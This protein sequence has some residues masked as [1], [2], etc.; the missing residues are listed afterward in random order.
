MSAAASVCVKPTISN[1]SFC[2]GTIYISELYYA[3]PLPKLSK[4]V[5]ELYTRVTYLAAE[6]L[7]INLG[8]SIRTDCGIAVLAEDLYTTL[9]NMVTTNKFCGRSKA[10]DV[11]NVSKIIF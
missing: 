11:N 5:N 7:C 10:S 3:T 1:V 8:P 2:S 4:C 6:N 9:V